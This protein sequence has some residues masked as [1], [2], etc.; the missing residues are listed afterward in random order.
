[1]KNITNLFTSLVL[2]DETFTRK[3]PKKIKFPSNLFVKVSEKRFTDEH[4]ETHQLLTVFEAHPIRYDSTFRSV[5]YGGST[6]MDMKAARD[7]VDGIGINSKHH[8]DQNVRV[9][10]NPKREQIRTRIEND[11]VAL[12]ERPIAIRFKKLPSGE[13]VMEMIDGRTRL[14]ILWRLGF[15]NVVVDLYKCSDSDAVRLGR[16]LNNEALPFGEGSSEDTEKALNRLIEYSKSGKDGLNIPC[17]WENVVTEAQKQKAREVIKAEAV[18]LSNNSLKPQ[19]LDRVIT[20]VAEKQTGSKMC[21]RFPNG[22][23]VEQY[24]NETLG[25]KSNSDIEYKCVMGGKLSSLI[26][27]EIVTWEPKY[28][29]QTLR[30]ILY[31]GSPNPTNL[32]ESWTKG[33]F[34]AKKLYDEFVEKVSKNMYNGVSPDMSNRS[35]HGAI[36]Q[37]DSLISKHPLKQLVIF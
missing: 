23:Q 6:L 4:L 14:D 1:M 32:E 31:V 2:K 28:P 34:G 16:L 10:E 11:G 5:K 13:T 18:L 8:G 9:K 17:G 30:V 35:V 29:K 26:Y 25:I 27:G 37:I 33:T 24:L 36:P 12:S 15:M 3:L 22:K 21:V 19:D 20:N 7:I